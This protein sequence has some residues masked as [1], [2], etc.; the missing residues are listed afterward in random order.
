M[1]P[2]LSIDTAFQQSTVEGGPRTF[3]GR[4]TARM[5]SSSGFISC[6][7]TAD[8][9]PSFFADD[10]RALISA[11]AKVLLWESLGE[12]EEQSC[13]KQQN[14]RK[15]W[16]KLRT[17]LKATA[18]FSSAGKV[19]FASRP[20]SKSKRQA[21]TAVKKWQK[22]PSFRNR[23]E[24]SSVLR[25]TSHLFAGR[26][27]GRKNPIYRT[28]Y[29]KFDASS[30]QLSYWLSEE[31]A[32]EGSAAT[33]RGII[34]V[35]RV[36]ASQTKTARAQAALAAAKEAAKEAAETGMRSSGLRG[37][38]ISRGLSR[39]VLQRHHNE[40]DVERGRCHLEVEVAGSGRVLQIKGVHKED[41]DAVVDIFE[42]TRPKAVS[43][44]C[45]SVSGKAAVQGK[46]VQ[47]KPVQGKPGQGKPVQGKVVQ[48]RVVA[49]GPSANKSK[50][51]LKSTMK[52]ND[53]ASLR[54]KRQE[55]NKRQ[56]AK[57][58]HTF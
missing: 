18:A 43:P 22:N 41:I 2:A 51:K 55:Y 29:F 23:E 56:M 39:M 42:S 9:V 8:T 45:I 54:A 12:G 57:Q 30:R 32:A 31:D 15:K 50:M 52:L 17:V 20:S 35:H 53:S 10:D 26:K 47:G 58:K 46:I 11:R 7:G 13:P 3:Q 48:G 36:C 49:L 33:R 38:R 16:Q 6:R 1:H 19:H 34:P 27:R 40:A 5:I 44:V 14:S 28:R 24:K 4:S 25:I 37:K 21:N